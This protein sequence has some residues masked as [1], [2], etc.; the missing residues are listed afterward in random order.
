MSLRPGRH[1]A[2]E[3]PFGRTAGTQFLKAALLIGSAVLLGVLLLHV[4]PGGNVSAVTRVLTQRTAL[5]RVSLPPPTTALVPLTPPGPRPAN[6]VRLLIANGTNVA[7]AA[8]RV[9]NQLAQAGYDT[10]KPPT[11]APTKDNATTTVYF[12]PSFQ[13]DGVGVAAALSLPASV[14]TAMPSPPP[15]PA[16]ALVAVDVLVI[17]GTDIANQIVGGVGGPAPP[18]TTARTTT[19]ARPTA[20]TARPTTTV[21][22][23]TTRPPTGASSTTTR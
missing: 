17:V 11:D 3:G 15:L 8:G 20:T 12:Q 4:G 9:R 6:Q 5:P 14:V 10:A 18:A 21:H 13:A 16:S 22:P 7:G 19:T 23:T 1:A 2:E